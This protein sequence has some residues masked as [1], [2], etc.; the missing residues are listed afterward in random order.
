[1]EQYETSQK[2]RKGFPVSVIVLLILLLLVAGF[3]GYLYYSV[4]KAPL[5]L[6]DPHKMA[7]SEPMDPEE[8]FCFF[9][10]DRSAQVKLDK[11]DLWYLILANTGDDYLDTINREL[12]DY[13]LTV[14]GCAIHMDPEGLRMDME[15]FFRDIR[16]VVKVPCDLEV[17]GQSLSLVP[18]GVRLG[19]IPLPVEGLLSAVKLEYDLVLPVISD[20]TQVTF[21]EDAVLLT[22]PLE[23]E[24][25]S[26]A[27]SES[28]L[29][30]SAAFCGIPWPMA[31]ALHTQEG[32]AEVL[33]QLE[34]DPGS[35]EGV[36]R[37]LF[38]LADPKDREAYLERR[39]GLTQRFFPGI[40]FSAVAAEQAAMQEQ[41]DGL[42]PAMDQ[43]FT[44]AVNDFNEK[45]FVLSGG[46]FYKNWQPFQAAQYGAG[47]FDAIF[48]QLDSESFF[49]ILVDAENGYIRKTS[50]LYRMVDA[51]QQFTREVDTNKTY[52]LGLVFRGVDGEPFLMYETEI[53]ENN[54]YYR[55]IVLHPLTE[56]EA[57]QLQVP[58]EFGVW[59]DNP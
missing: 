37:E 29:N 56:E 59:T 12:E 3:V 25:Q 14:S 27:P 24:L 6:D 40:H 46:I 8:R 11:G 48:Q 18:T 54:T 16:L 26:L 49:L 44:K 39:L 34:R 31:E 43:F 9:A 38:T 1:M 23:P 4:V 7:A 28:W 19:V 33:M 21:A 42:S 45:N 5:E 55:E 58:G 30:R 32:Y 47:E 35:V 51:Y 53:Q 13:S 52:I 36:Y 17:N 22:G 50:S 41:M 2:E 57:A 15:L 10:A 20:V